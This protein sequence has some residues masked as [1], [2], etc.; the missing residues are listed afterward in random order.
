MSY[1][2]K[3]NCDII[4]K[5]NIVKEQMPIPIL[6]STFKQSQIISIEDFVIH[7]NTIQSI[8]IDISKLRR[9]IT[10]NIYKE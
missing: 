3:L 9:F 1:Y 4:R 10:I 8:I 2:G 7:T 5:I 6:S